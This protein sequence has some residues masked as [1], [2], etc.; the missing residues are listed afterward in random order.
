MAGVASKSPLCCARVYV[1][2]FA[3]PQAAANE[4][5]RRH[6]ARE[7]GARTAQ[8]HRHGDMD[9][10][11]DVETDMNMGRHGTWTWTW[12][13]SSCVYVCMR[14][15]VRG[16]RARA[17]V[18]EPSW[19]AAE[20]ISILYEQMICMQKSFGCVQER[21]ELYNYVCLFSV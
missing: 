18:C 20:R 6:K 3:P 13:L 2:D 9:V 17:C 1:C 4:Y 11:M 16:T 5:T 19:R 15:C 10:D 8:T 14:V 7:G 12:E 21:D